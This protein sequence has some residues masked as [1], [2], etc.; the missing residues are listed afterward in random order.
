M[1]A[2]EVDGTVI[3]VTVQPPWKGTYNIVC[4][5]LRTAPKVGSGYNNNHLSDVLA[6]H[7]SCYME[8]SFF[9]I[10]TSMKHDGIRRVS[11]D[12]VQHY[13]KRN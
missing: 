10:W 5:R 7:C 13:F 3:W 2:Q 4:L 6:V 11:G 12:Q 9:E 8:T 1:S